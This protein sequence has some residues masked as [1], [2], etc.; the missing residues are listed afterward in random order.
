V[1]SDH[2]VSTTGGPFRFD[3]TDVDEDGEYVATVPTPHPRN[4]MNPLAER[5]TEGRA[6]PKGIPVLYLSTDQET[7]MS[8]VRPAVGTFLSV[9]Q[10]EIRRDLC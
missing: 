4:R 2:A 5:A 1:N 9:A 10:F 6:N 8:G 7:A 3:W